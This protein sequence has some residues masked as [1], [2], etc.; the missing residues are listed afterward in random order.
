MRPR[1]IR[2]PAIVLTEGYDGTVWST[3]PNMATARRFISGAGTATLG[4]GFGGNP[5]NNSTEEFTGE[6][7]TGNITDFATS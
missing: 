6:T 7:S 3:R 5:P 1:R 2:S 4:I